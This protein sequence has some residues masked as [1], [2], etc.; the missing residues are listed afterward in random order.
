MEGNDICLREFAQPHLQSTLRM[1]P[2]GPPGFEVMTG[3]LHTRLHI[4][5]SMKTRRV[6]TYLFCVYH[7][8][9]HEHNI[10]RPYIYG[11]CKNSKKSK[12]K[13]DKQHTMLGVNFL[14]FA[15]FMSLWKHRALLASYII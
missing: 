6:G 2:E 15:Y 4:H 13:E 5:N 14:H 11:Q 7:V 8:H 10:Q 3:L 9:R 1:S 12:G